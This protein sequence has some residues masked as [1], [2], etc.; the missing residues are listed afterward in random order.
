MG[1]DSPEF[2]T[3]SSLFQ[4]TPVGRIGGVVWIPQGIEQVDQ[5]FGGFGGEQL[6]QLRI[7]F[8]FRHPVSFQNRFD[9]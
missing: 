4:D 5:L 2:T 8:Q 9:V 6:F 7:R 1:S 3:S